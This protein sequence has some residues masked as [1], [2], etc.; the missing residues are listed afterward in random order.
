VNS[1]IFTKIHSGYQS[2]FRQALV[3][4]MMFALLAFVS[5]LFPNTFKM[6]LVE[7]YLPFHIILELV[8]II[9]AMQVSGIA[10]NAKKHKISGK[11]IFLS[12]VFFGVAILDM[13]HFL[14]YEGMAD[15]IT[16]NSTDKAIYF[17]LCARFLSSVGLFIFALYTFAKIDSR[18][19]HYLVF[20]LIIVFVGLLHWP[21]IA[22]SDTLHRLFFV[23][24][25][26]LTSL[27]I[28]LE[29]ILIA[30]NLLTAFT[31]YVKMQEKQEYH[32]V[33]LF[34]AVCMMAISEFLLTLYSDITDFYNIL[35]HV[36]KAIAYILFIEQFL[37]LQL[38]NLTKSCR[39]FNSSSM[40]K[41]S[42]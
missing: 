15:F 36:Y 24:D 25:N 2:S 16:P 42:Y 12:A 38:I 5:W 18:K 34:A 9:I 22:D 10:W 3:V 7:D 40:K 33:A 14:S 21:L 17:W 31:F 37:S 23:Q 26:G 39:Y 29:Y 30:I 32:I 35:G 8:S 27:K 4:V 1:N 11:I 41:I 28:T 20:A 19:L 13:T 6:E